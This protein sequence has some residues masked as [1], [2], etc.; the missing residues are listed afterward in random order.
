MS[1]APGSYDPRSPGFLADPYPHYARLRAENP[2][3]RTRFGF[4]ILTRHRDLRAAYDSTEL[5]RNTRLW[6]GFESWRRGSTDGPLEQMMKNWLVMIDP[7]RHTPLRAIHERAFDRDRISSFQPVIEKIVADLLDAAAPAGGMDAV[8]DFADKLP[9]YVI[10]QL[11]GLPRE[12]WDQFVAWSRAISQTSEAFLTRKVLAEG[13]TALAGLYAYLRPLAERRRKDPGDD[14]LSALATIES[15]GVRLADEVLLDSLVFLY[16]AGHPTGGQ[17]LALALHSLLRHPDQL[18]RLRAEPGLL[19]GA[20]EELQR[21]DGPVQMNDRVAVKDMTFAGVEL[22]AGE[23]V[24]LCIAAA[25]RDPEHFPDPDRLDLGRTPDGQLGYGRGLHYC[26]GEYLGRV[27]TRVAIG[28]LLDRAPGLRLSDEEV[29]FLP[30]VSNRG[31][32]R[33]MVAF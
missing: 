9:V 7:P 11:L 21:Y 32:A 30:S 12:D 17:L 10:N 14:L 29:T 15:D 2:I 25:N 27:Q 6:D 26:I 24:R 28:R 3:H 19:P 1:D 16:Q 33:M 4:V 5:S 20:V 31:L 8:T 13:E 18:A 23:L 22:A